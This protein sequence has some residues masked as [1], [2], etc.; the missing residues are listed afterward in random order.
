MPVNAYVRGDV[1]VARGADSRIRVGRRTIGRERRPMF[2]RRPDWRRRP[3]R[4]HEC[5]Y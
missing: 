5:Q 1:F 2:R 3:A 4:E